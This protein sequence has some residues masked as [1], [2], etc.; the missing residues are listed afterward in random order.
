MDVDSIIAD[1]F[2]YHQILV[3]KVS[4]VTIILYSINL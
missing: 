1:C 3:I 4:L 2:H